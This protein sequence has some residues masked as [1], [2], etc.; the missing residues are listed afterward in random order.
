MSNY[1]PKPRFMNTE[2]AA[3]ELGISRRQVQRLI[4]QGV[5]RAKRLRAGR[6]LLIELAEIDRFIKEE[7]VAA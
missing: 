7:M 4:E 6:G 1:T 3:V 5:L 2:A